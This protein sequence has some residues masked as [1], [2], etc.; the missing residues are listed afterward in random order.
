MYTDYVILHILK[1]SGIQES[2]QQ[3]GTTLYLVDYK[4]AE[5]KKL[6]EVI[7]QVNGLKKYV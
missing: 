7:L 4:T 5:M 2:L 3:V 6:L 1:Y